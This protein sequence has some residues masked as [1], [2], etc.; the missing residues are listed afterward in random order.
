MVALAFVWLALLVA[1][2]V[3]GESRPFFMIGT[4]VWVVFIVDFG[5]KLVLATRRF[6]Y[7]RRNWPS[8]LSSL[9]PTLRVV[10]IVRVVRL[11]R[12]ARVGRGLRLFR[13]LSSL[14]RG[15]RALGASLHRRGFAYIVA[16]TTVVVVAGSAGMFAFER[17]G[18]GGIDSYGEA[19]WRTAMVMTTLGSGAWP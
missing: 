10:R 14:N 18:V 1:G 19:L 17:R 13:L 15:M 8:A 4:V 6:A 7:L 2:L 16:L 5:T 12:L 3:W 9:V 11:L